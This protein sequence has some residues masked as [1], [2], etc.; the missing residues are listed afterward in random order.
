MHQADSQIIEYI[1]GSL[2]GDYQIPKCSI[3]S[4]TVDKK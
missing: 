4:F 3:C 1:S 2:A